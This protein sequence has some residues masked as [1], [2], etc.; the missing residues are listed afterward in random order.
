[1]S[2]F[3]LPG[4]CTT[5][6]RV[7]ACEVTSTGAGAKSKKGRFEGSAESATIDEG[8]K[9]YTP[10]KRKRPLADQVIE[11]GTASPQRKRSRLLPGKLASISKIQKKIFH[12]AQNKHNNLL[13]RNL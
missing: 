1:M 2:Y 13:Y 3:V 6:L 9:F 4:H 12:A 5:E 11:L 7:Q 10:G 8:G